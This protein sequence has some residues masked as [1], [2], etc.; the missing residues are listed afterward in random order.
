MDRAVPAIGRLRVA[1]LIETSN[2]YGRDL[3][4]G[5]HDWMSD[6]GNWS[7]RFTEQSRLAP[8]PEWLRTWDGDGIIARVDTDA[9]ARTLRRLGKPVVDVSAERAKSEFARVTVDNVGVAHLA[10]EHLRERGLPHFAFCGDARFL[11]STQRQRAY[12]ARLRAWKRRVEVFE[13][14]GGVETSEAELARLDA[15]LL[16]LPKPVGVFVCYD[17]RAQQVLEACQRTGLQVP[18]RV[19]VVGVDNDE[20]VCDLCAPPLSSVLP[21]ARRAGFEA[22]RQ[23]HAAMNS[24]RAPVRRSRAIEPIRVVPRQSTDVINVDDPALAAAVRYIR[25][26]A[27]DGI[28]VG[29][30]LP[31]AG[32]S[33]THFERRFKHALGESP[34]RMIQTA[35]LERV[36]QLLTETDL[37]IARIADLSGF[38]S[39][40]Y[41]SAVFRR[42]QGETPFEFRRKRRARVTERD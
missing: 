25:S 16:A 21:N 33:R 3:L 20:V 27:G 4:H 22:A 37:P 32:M 17:G 5:V 18:G 12:A 34:H 41:L 10:A 31:V 29:D 35:R 2:R 36:R 1:L 9:A 26:H 42:E 7:V 40:S 8:L 11:W 23:L 15:W 19:A 30:V 39:P 28:D 14:A 38:Q 13:F 6:A 24:G